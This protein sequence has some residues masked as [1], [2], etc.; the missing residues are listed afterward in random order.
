MRLVDASRSCGVVWV[1]LA[2]GSIAVAADKGVLGD[3]LGDLANTVDKLASPKPAT[4]PASQPADAKRPDPGRGILGDDL[5]DLEKRV[6]GLTKPPGGQ[7]LPATLPGTGGDAQPPVIAG[8]AEG[9]INRQE[10]AFMPNKGVTIADGAMTLLSAG[11]HGSASA[12]FRPPLTGDFEVRIAFTLPSEAVGKRADLSRGLGIRLE[13]DAGWKQ[14][15][16]LSIDRTADKEGDVILAGHS[17]QLKDPLKARP[18]GQ[19][20]EIRVQRKGNQFRVALRDG[21]AAD[22]SEL[23]TVQAEMSP[24]LQLWVTTYVTLGEARGVVRSVQVVEG[25]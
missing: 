2:L 25:K 21:D 20:C 16:L 3:D 17:D 1:L 15:R 7:K 5:G 18:K 6:D 9:K 11:A 13:S 4:R 22:W 23:G 10:W 14:E 8:G 12:W 19:T 24:E